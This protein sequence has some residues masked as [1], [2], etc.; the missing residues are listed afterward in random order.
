L[1]HLRS[2]GVSYGYEKGAFSTIPIRWD[3]KA[4]TFTIGQRSGTHPGITSAREVRVVFVSK[5][6]PIGHTPEPKAQAV[7]YDGSPV[8]V[9]RDGDG[10]AR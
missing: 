8:V 7:R 4:G 3:E 9:K 1:Y 10:A 5:E 2:D 6:A